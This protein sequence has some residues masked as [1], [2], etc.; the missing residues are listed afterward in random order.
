VP[1][2][3]QRPRKT[4]I[5]GTAANVERE[6]TSI[7]RCKIPLWTHPR[8]VKAGVG[9]AGLEIIPAQGLHLGSGSSGLV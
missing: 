5:D 8:S 1:G 4:G 7:Y 2:L 9:G 6:S 3:A